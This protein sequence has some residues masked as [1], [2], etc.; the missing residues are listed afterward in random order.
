MHQPYTRYTRLPDSDSIQKQSW[1]PFF[2]GLMSCAPFFVGLLFV[3]IVFL[4]PIGAL[5]FK[6]SR[7]FINH[8]IQYKSLATILIVNAMDIVLLPPFVFLFSKR[9]FFCKF[10]E[11]AK[12]LLYSCV[13]ML[14]VI[15][16]GIVLI[17][18][19]S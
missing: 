18:E 19:H 15:Q 17:S 8:T 7:V 12:R 9:F 2:R 11:D 16:Y 13:T 6:F 10:S 5:Q 3:L 4:V 14:Y 1:A